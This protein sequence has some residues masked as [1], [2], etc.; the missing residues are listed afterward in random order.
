MPASGLAL[1][2]DFV[3]DT[4]IVVAWAFRE[5]GRWGFAR[6]I[7]DAVFRGDVIAHVPEL[8]WPEF[9]QTAG[10]KRHKNRQQRDG[11]GLPLAAVD[12][13]YSSVVALPLDEIA[14]LADMDLRDDAW[15]L[16]RRLEVG[17]YDA[18]VLA[19]ARA[20]DLELWTFDGS[21][22]ADVRPDPALRHRVRHVGVDITW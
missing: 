12:V 19:L 9:Q 16:R 21:L 5:R 20:L 15:Q 8:F 11:L 13:A 4:S 10:Y 3:L 22:C 7:L 14:V 17:S 1:P 18:H 2:A 6:D